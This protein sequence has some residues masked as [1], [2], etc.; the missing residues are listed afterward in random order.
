MNKI[1]IVGGNPITGKHSKI[2]E[3]LG[4]ELDA[5][6]VNGAI[7]RVEKRDLIIWMPDFSN[8][9]DKIYPKK[10]QGAVLICSKVMREGYTHVDS[11][12][13]IFK[14]GG[15]AVIEIYPVYDGMVKRF[16]FQLVDALGNTWGDRSES[17]TKLKNSIIDLY[18]W[19]KGSVRR[20][21]TQGP[22]L[23][24]EPD[25]DEFYKFIQINRRLALQCAEGCGNRFFGNYSTRC[26]KLFPASRFGSELF[27]VSPR[28]I[29]KNFVTAQDMVVCDHNTYYS[30]RKPSI[31][32]PVQLELYRE[33]PLVNYMIH[34]HAYIQGAAW[35]NDYYPCGDMREIEGIIR[36][37]RGNGSLTTTAINLKNHGFLILTDTIEELN[38]TWK[39]YP[40]NP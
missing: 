2:A 34:G 36:V 1:L 12:S 13:R 4:K 15:N 16:E 33:F 5:C 22:C 21:L 7:S 37:V 31:D 29:D 40:L 9:E 27:A 30:T 26:T 35:T 6:V 3:L 24:L 23:T 39:F 38:R 32:T 17:L 25:L 18:L 8:D 11:V 10:D 14:M 20:S 19:T 28:N